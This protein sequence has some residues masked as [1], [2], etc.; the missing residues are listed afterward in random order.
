MAGAKGRRRAFPGT[1]APVMTGT[2]PAT[3]HQPRPW[4]LYLL[5]CV[6]GKLYAGISPDPEARFQLHLRGGGARYTRA[7]PPLRILAA[8]AYADRS[9]ASAAEYA[10]KQLPRAAK[11]RWAQ[12]RPWPL[13]PARKARPSPRQPAA[14][15]SVKISGGQAPRRRVRGKSAE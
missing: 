1:L 7:N 12:E 3:S 10:L 11:L 15:K 14:R 2:K 6:G 8:Q 5:E 9:A 13:K 4:L